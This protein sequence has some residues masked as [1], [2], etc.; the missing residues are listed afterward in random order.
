M[1]LYI[2]RHAEAAPLGGRIHRDADRPLTSVGEKDAANI[3][4]ALA[5]VDINITAIVTS[6][7]VRAVRTGGL[8]GRELSARPIIQT[9]EHLAP[10]FNHQRLL[11]ELLAMGQEGSVVAVGHQPDVGMFVSSLVADYS[12]PVLAMPPGA[13]AALT[14]ESS[15]GSFYLNWLLTPELLRNTQASFL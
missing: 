10:G 9:N 11:E 7:L 12:Q 13:I 1:N 3:G 6:P 5:R 14:G 15:Q 4:R 8:I 2:V